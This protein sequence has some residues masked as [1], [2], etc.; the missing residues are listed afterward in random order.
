MQVMEKQS[1]LEYTLLC[2]TASFVAT[3]ASGIIHPLELI[4]TRF[5]SMNQL[6]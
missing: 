6:K 2:G 4:K 1:N 5:Q 3:F